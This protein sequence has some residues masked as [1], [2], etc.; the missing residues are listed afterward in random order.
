MYAY[1]CAYGYMDMKYDSIPSHYQST[2]FKE[3]WVRTW[4]SFINIRNG[5]NSY[6]I[7]TC[8][9]QLHVL[10]FVLQFFFFSVFLTPSSNLFVYYKSPDLYEP[11]TDHTQHDV[12]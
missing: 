9:Y 2:Y 12:T 3:W 5:T 6:L 10:K 11:K 4:Q 1:V 8:L 7:L